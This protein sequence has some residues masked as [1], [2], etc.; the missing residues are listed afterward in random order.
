VTRSVSCSCN[1]A[2]TLSRGG[3]RI[4]WSIRVTLTVALL[5]SSA[6]S[7]GSA[8]A[9]TAAASCQGANLPPSAANV[10]AVDAVTLCLVDE[11]RTAHHLRP[12]RPNQELHAVAARQ[13][14]CVVRWNDFAD[15]CPSGQTPWAQIAATPY[16]TH[17]AGLSIGQTLGWGTG[18]YR[19]PAEMVAA[20]MSS[21]PHREIILTGAFN[22]AGVGVAPA[23]PSILGAGEPGATYAIEFAGRLF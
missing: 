3:R 21:P 1:H 20:W 9:R 5:I 11:V 4:L 19:T 10:A 6:L 13:V 17:A 14:N 7:A 2:G 12:L 8:L 22:D 15:D 23:V 18:P 16:G